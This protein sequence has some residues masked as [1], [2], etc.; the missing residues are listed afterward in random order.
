MAFDRAARTELRQLALLAGPIFV[1]QFAQAAFGFIDTLMAG[2]VSALDL[3]AVAVGASIWLPLYLLTTGT[4]LAV[5]PLIAEARGAGREQDVVGITQQGFWLALVIT[6]IGFAL[7]RVSPL[8][9]DAMAVEPGLRI[10]TAEFLHAISWGMPAVGLFYV[11]RCYCEA[12]QRPLPVTLISLAGLPLNVAANRV[13][14]DGSAGLPGL[15]TLD[16]PA[17]GGP[18]CGWGTTTVLWSM[19]AA[20]LVYVLLAPHFAHTRL[21][22]RWHEPDAAALKRMAALGLPIGLAIFF[23]VSSFASV[24]VLV[25]PLG[26]TV[27][28]GHQVAL[29]VTSILFM[30]PLSTAIALTIRTGHAFGAG[31]HEAIR[32]TCRTGLRATTI[33]AC[34]SALFLL[35]ARHDIA[36]LY[37]KDPAVCAL[38]A[39]L[40]LFAVGYQVVDALQV[41]AAG[42]LRGM[43][44]TRTPMRLTLIAYWVVAIPF[45]WLA[46]STNVLG[47]AWGPYGYWMGLVLGLAV[48]ALLLNR[49]LRRR[50]AQLP[51]RSR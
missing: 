17:M 46:G 13:F 16:I 18:G 2:Q 50:L 20:L 38:A 32:L 3:A 10:K 34:V 40:M 11:L 45:G 28:A 23:E 1:S 36:A 47:R 51:L 21:L 14:I 37:S 33:I 9:F 49:Q 19:T 29:S 8:L 43:Q 30:V 44:D 25:S 42:C 31:D 4:L 48:A 15:A 6:L 22:R 39:Q 5:T 35:L 26:A 12:Q 7:I 27:V 24:A 41:G